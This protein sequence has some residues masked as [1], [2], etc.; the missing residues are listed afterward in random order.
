MRSHSSNE[1]VL[2]EVVVYVNIVIVVLIFVA[3]IRFS[4]GQ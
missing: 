1:I 4:C 3:V 2:L